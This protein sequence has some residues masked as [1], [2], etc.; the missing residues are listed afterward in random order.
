MRKHH[1]RVWNWDLVHVCLHKKGFK[2]FLFFVFLSKHCGCQV[3]C[4]LACRG[5]IP[6]LTPKP[7]LRF[8]PPCATS[9]ALRQPAPLPLHIT[10]ATSPTWRAGQGAVRGSDRWSRRAV[11]GAVPAHFHKC[12]T[13]A[14]VF[15][16]PCTLCNVLSLK[17]WCAPLSSM[18]ITQSAGQQPFYTTLYCGLLLSGL[19]H[20]RPSGSNC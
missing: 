4:V 5:L 11:P 10:H 9:P 7:A 14:H 1:F 20:S 12:L 6:C 2:S 16:G 8:S 15:I 3:A 18:F 13:H 17:L 19:I